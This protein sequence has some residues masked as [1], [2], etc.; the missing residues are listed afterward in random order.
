[1][2]KTPELDFSDAP[3]V[4]RNLTE[5]QQE[6]LTEVLDEYLRQLE[7][8]KQ[9]DRSE[10]I[11]ANPDLSHALREYLSKLDE[12][13]WFVSGDAQPP[14]VVGKQLGDYRLIRE[15]GRGGM[16]IVYLAQQISLDRQVAVKLLP[17]ASLLEPKYIERFKNE[18]RAA[19][20]LEHPNIVP[21]YSVGHD[22]GIHYYAMRYI[23]GQSLDQLIADA[24][25]A[26]D[27]T[28]GTGESGAS[29]A[30][31]KHTVTSTKLAAV[32]EQFAEVAEAL[33]CAHEYGVVHRDIKPSNLLCDERQKLW[34][35]DFGLARFQSNRPL[36]RTGEM[37]GTL[38]Y[39]SPEQAAGQAELIDLRTDIY[40]LGATLYELLTLRPAVVG[41][42]G[43]GLMNIIE[44]DAPVRIRKLCPEIPRDVQTLVEKAMSKHREDRYASAQLFAADLRRA[45]RGYPILANPISPMMLALRWSEKHRRL[46]AVALSI[47]T[48]ATC[49]LLVSVILISNEKQETEKSLA[50]AK[51]RYADARTA[52]EDLGNLVADELAGFP[53]AE[54]VRLRVLKKTLDYYQRF[55]E[56]EANDPILKAD[57]ALTYSRIGKWTEELESTE[58]A[59]EHYRHAQLIYEQLDPE[60][61]R[62]TDIRRQ[63]AEN[64]NALGLALTKLGQNSQAEQAYRAALEIH[65]E[66]PSSE[67]TQQAD[68]GITRNNY[69]LFL[70]R[71]GRT[72]QAASTIS[73]AIALLEHAIAADPSDSRATRALGAAYNNLGSVQ[74]QSDP[75]AAA[76]SFNRALDIQLPMTQNSGHRLRASLDLVASYNNL[77]SALYQV[78]D[79]TGAEQAHRKAI[80]ISR[81]LAAIAPR[82]ELYR[83]DLAISL[84]NVGLALREQGQLR[85][86]EGAFR[87]SI[88]LQQALF[89]SD[90]HKPALA[91]NLGSVWGNLALI[92]QAQMDLDESNKA[93]LEAIKLQRLAYEAESSNTRFRENLGK[94]LANQWGLLRQ[95]GDVPGELTV[96][97]ERRKLWI[98]DADRLLAIAEDLAL[99]ESQSPELINELVGTLQSARDAGLKID[100]ALLGRVPFR[101]LG[102]EFRHKLTV[103]LDKPTH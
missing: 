42:E 53:G 21:V 63:Q 61:F 48:L 64:L 99:V 73:E 62:P 5:Q 19:A 2:N 86:A 12:L 29:H 17:F 56:Q 16:G 46:L 68:L 7:A 88:E 75:Q 78:Q 43:P 4:L 101:K 30:P 28:D 3:E 65:S 15:L 51:L 41:P 49:G 76:Q 36:T 79:W 59:V 20:Q 22:Q 69:G 25:Q 74:S 40:S 82:V 83:Q 1:M 58:A 84:N 18:A 47:A 100:E 6:R 8:G 35:A 9:Q 67:V 95:L 103:A 97:A 66:S 94:S 13:N 60:P 31:G 72:E 14:D 45:S 11:A 38:R 34:L 26:H 92:L 37:I 57:L 24:R 52:V 89:D 70:Q 10:L 81:Q 27:A 77:G 96:A 85:E 39:M 71:A 44:R 98:G 33:H 93:F 90:A 55:S 80:V 32:L 87:E 102:T 91:S 23:A 50:V 54:S